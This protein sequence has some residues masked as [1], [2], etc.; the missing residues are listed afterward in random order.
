MLRRLLFSSVVVG[1]GLAVLQV[2]LGSMK[3]AIEAAST[4]LRV[5]GEPQSAG[6]RA[7]AGLH[8]SES[9]AFGHQPTSRKRLNHAFPSLRLQASPGGPRRS[10]KEARLRDG[11]AH[12]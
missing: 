8:R 3:P 9:I 12:S 5:T 1:A 2:W 11:P 4:P 6:T 7:V 10:T